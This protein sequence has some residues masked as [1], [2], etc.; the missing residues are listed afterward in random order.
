MSTNGRR[1]GEHS[2]LREP[3]SGSPWGG[4]ERGTQCVLGVEGSRWGRCRLSGTWWCGWGKKRQRVDIIRCTWRMDWR[5]QEGRWETWW[6]GTQI[7][8]AGNGRRHEAQ[9]WRWGWTE[10]VAGP[11]DHSE[12]LTGVSCPWLYNK[13]PQTSR[14]NRAISSWFYNLGWGRLGDSSAG[15]ASGFQCQVTW[16]TGWA[17]SISFSPWILRTTPSL[18]GLSSRT[19]GLFTWWLRCPKNTKQEP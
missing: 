9:S 4:K 17:E 8:Q 6:D 11:T 1:G 19:A 2:R 18:S 12:K 16:D 10:G 15:L 3:H 13:H 7:T 5:G 14:N